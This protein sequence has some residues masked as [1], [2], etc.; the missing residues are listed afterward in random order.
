MAHLLWL[1]WMF[2][3]NVKRMN[4]DSSYKIFQKLKEE[5][6]HNSFYETSIKAKPRHHRGISHAQ[7]VKNPPVTWET[8][9][10][11][12][13]WK[14]SPGGEHGNPLQLILQINNL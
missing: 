8:W 11:S 7:M 10:W 5:I 6:F 9:V 1:Y 13:G 4:N 14:D 12:L 2:L 3:W